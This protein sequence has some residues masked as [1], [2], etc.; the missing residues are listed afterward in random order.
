MMGHAEQT[1]RTAA[2]L[3]DVLATEELARRPARP[4]DFEAENRALVRLAREMATHPET[5]LQKLV[6]AAL[7]LCRA[8]SAGVSILEPCD[9][10]GV[11]RWHAVAGRFAPNV[12][13]TMPRDLSPCGAVLDR[14]AVLL[15]ADPARHFPAVAAIDL[16]VVETLLVPFHAGGRPVGTVWV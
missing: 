16:P 13:G 4:P 9:G 11:F 8:E 5:I 12:G 7:E 10:P 2:R 1:G 14:D 6:D 3:E 15:F